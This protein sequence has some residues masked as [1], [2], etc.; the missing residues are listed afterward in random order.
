VS[1]SP[2]AIRSICRRVCVLEHG[3][4]SFDGGVDDG[5]EFYE[6]SLVLRGS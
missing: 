2:T 5:L 4:L 1:H 6:R 3:E